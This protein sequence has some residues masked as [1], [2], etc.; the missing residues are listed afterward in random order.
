MY[1]QNTTASATTIASNAKYAR[2]RSI[3]DFIFDTLRPRLSLD[4]KIEVSK[5][6]AQSDYQGAVAAI[7]VYAKENFKDA[8]DITAVMEEKTTGLGNLVNQ[9]VTIWQDYFPGYLMFKKKVD[10][11]PKPKKSPKNQKK[12]KL[13]KEKKNT[14]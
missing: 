4:G 9:M 1:G 13:K 7:R 5:A 14:S 2:S 6:Y 3:Y 11:K 12:E 8:Y 10:N